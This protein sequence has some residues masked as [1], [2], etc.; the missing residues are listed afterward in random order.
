MSAVFALLLYL[1]YLHLPCSISGFLMGH[2]IGKRSADLVIYTEESALF[3]FA[4]ALF[5]F[6]VVRWSLME[7]DGV[8]WTGHVIQVG[9]AGM[10]GWIVGLVDGGIVGPADG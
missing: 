10:I 7:S 2:V 9:H 3:L 1:S 6:S 5:L 8:R 4:F